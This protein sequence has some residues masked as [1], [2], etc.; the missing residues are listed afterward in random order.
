MPGGASL[1]GPTHNRRHNRR[2]DKT[3]YVAIRHRQDAA[4]NSS[5]S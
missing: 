5:R 3:L 2:P 4:I 1:T